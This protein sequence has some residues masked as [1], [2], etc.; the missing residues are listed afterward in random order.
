MFQDFINVA[1]ES[2]FFLFK[3]QSQIFESFLKPNYCKN[4]SSQL[5]I[6]QDE[7]MQSF[8]FTA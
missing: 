7:T 2:A 3:K 1:K 6:N 4:D 8:I 5:L